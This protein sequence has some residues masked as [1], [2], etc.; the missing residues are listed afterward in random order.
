[1]FDGIN[2]GFILN[3]LLPMLDENYVANRIIN[4]IR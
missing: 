2:P 1:M 3:M 4:A